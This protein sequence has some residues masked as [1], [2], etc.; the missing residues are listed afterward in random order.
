M[1]LAPLRADRYGRLPV[2]RSV[3][4]IAG[5]RLPT[6]GVTLARAPRTAAARYSPQRGT[7]SS[8]P[9]LMA[10]LVIALAVMIS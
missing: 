1:V 4:V 5:L 2:P 7:H 8:C 10:P 6:G 3:I 9:A